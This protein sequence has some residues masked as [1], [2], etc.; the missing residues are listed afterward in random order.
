M[1]RLTGM[2]SWRLFSRSLCNN[3][4]V[5]L[6]HFLNEWHQKT[7]VSLFDTK[8]KQQNRILP[9]YPL[10]RLQVKKRRQH[11]HLS[12][13]QRGILIRAQ[14]EA[15]GTDRT[16]MKLPNEKLLLK[17]FPQIRGSTVPLQRA[18]YRKHHF[19]K[20]RLYPKP[21]KPLQFPF[22]SSADWST[23]L[24]AAGCN[25][26]PVV[27]WHETKK[28][29]STDDSSLLLYLTQAGNRKGRCPSLTDARG[30]CASATAPW[31][32]LNF[33]NP[34]LALSD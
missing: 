18:L 19:A 27:F 24:R 28:N 26:T 8:T 16:V 1:P 15:R 29:P 14:G 31:R 21:Y 30:V 20:L 25:V 5:V 7:Y 13:V 32:I 22:L 10:N 12:W 9:T 11:Q 4:K 17:D 34:F 2:T 3:L 6:K 33:D 23:G